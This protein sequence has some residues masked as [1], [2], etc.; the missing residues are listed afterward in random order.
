MWVFSRIGPEFEAYAGF[1]RFTAFV[2][3]AAV[4]ASVFYLKKDPDH[5][6]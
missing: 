2:G 4:A 1:A 5:P 6:F 3:V